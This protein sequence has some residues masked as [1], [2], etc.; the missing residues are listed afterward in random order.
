MKKFVL[1][2]KQAIYRA[3]VFMLRFFWTLTGGRMVTVFGQNISLAPATV[4]PSYRNLRLPSGD[5]A[6]QIVRYADYVQMHSMVRHVSQLKSPAVIIDIGA[7]HGAYAIVLGKILQKTGGKIIAVEPNPI[8]FSVL[9]RNVKLNGLEG[10]IICER[11]AVSDQAGKMNISLEDVQSGIS[12]QASSGSVA[13]DVLTLRMLMEK[14]NIEH[15]DVLQIDVEGAEI[16]V[17]NGFSWDLATVGK[18]YCELHPY[19]WP[20]FGYSGLDVQQFLSVHGL[21]CFDMYLQ[22]HRYFEYPDYIG[23]ALLIPRQ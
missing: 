17:L 18:I 4:F 10:T 9:E 12:N 8:S 15:V 19:A 21:Q 14:Y 7:H 3:G 11:V 13:V 2:I 23:P 16:P 20:D 6:S 5:S 22:E 1:M